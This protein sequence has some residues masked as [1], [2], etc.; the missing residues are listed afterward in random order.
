MYFSNTKADS[1]QSLTVDNQ[2]ITSPP[3]PSPNPSSSLEF[4][5]SVQYQ[6]AITI[7]PFKVQKKTTI[8]LD[9]TLIKQ[10]LSPE[11]SPPSPDEK[12]IQSTPMPKRTLK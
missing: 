5:S 4:T 8:S 7:D 3:R 9:T 10:V 2:P 11:V 1:P 12:T 6:E